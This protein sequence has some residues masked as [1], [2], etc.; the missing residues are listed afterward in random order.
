VEEAV[1]AYFKTLSEHLPG[2][3]GKYGTCLVTLSLQQVSIFF[4][5]P[6]SFNLHNIPDF[7]FHFSRLRGTSIFIVNH[8]MFF[9]NWPSSRVV[10]VL[11]DSA[12]L[13]IVSGYL[14]LVLCCCRAHV[15]YMVMPYA[16]WRSVFLRT[17]VPI[18]YERSTLHVRLSNKNQS[19]HS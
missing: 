14:I 13:V 2:M 10:I 4:L 11:N 18:T 19:E 9:S 17:E 16:T 15:W 6:W 5:S 7:M 12:V 3:T 1:I 8:Y